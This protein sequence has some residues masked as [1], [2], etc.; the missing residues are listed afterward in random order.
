MRRRIGDN[1]ELARQLIP[2]WSFGCKLTHF[3]IPRE[4]IHL[5]RHVLGRRLTPGNGYLESLSKKNAKLATS[6]I[7]E[8]TS[9]GIVTADGQHEAFDVIVCATGFNVSFQPRWLQQGRSG[10]DLAKE[11]SQDA[12]SYFSLGVS[13]QPNH[14]IFNGPAAPVA[15]GSLPSAIDWVAEYILKWV[16][17]MSREDI[18]SFDVRPDVQDDWNIWGDELLKRT[19]WASGC[20]SWYKRNGRITALYPG[21]ILHFKD[22]IADIR[23]EDFHITYR[24]KN[25]WRCL[26]NGFTEREVKGGSLAYYIEH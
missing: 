17:K 4:S 20:S 11:W 19:V 13:G 9:T 22:A 5:D 1:G 23:G 25:R 14:F 7:R 18:K 24:S 16:T 10:R 3:L 6:T 2:T 15:H 8:I 26:G 21:S 12:K